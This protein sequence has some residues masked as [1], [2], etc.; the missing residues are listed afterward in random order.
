MNTY[1]D[2][3]ELCCSFSNSFKYAIKPSIII[4]LPKF[5]STSKNDN[6]TSSLSFFLFFQVFLFLLLLLPST[7]M[8]TL[9]FVSNT[10]IY[11][12]FLDF[13]FCFQLQLSHSIL[14]IFCDYLE[15][16]N[17][18]QENIWRYK[19]YFESLLEQYTW[20]SNRTSTR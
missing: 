17:L 15:A 16:L 9:I 19:S 10:C 3:F 12:Q 8:I 13:T 4:C 20:C 11:W 2:N 7:M 14:T 1:K 6:W 5:T 18:W